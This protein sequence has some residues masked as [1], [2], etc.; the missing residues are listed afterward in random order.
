MT[1]LLGRYRALEAPRVVGLMSGTS[2][3]AIDAALVEVGERP[4]LLEFRSH[5]LPD[6]V[7]ARL[8]EVFDDRGTPRELTRLHW[9][10]GELFARAALSVMD[11]GADLVAS[12]GQT[13]AHLPEA[14]E[15]CGESVRGTL[16]LGEA[17]V[18]ARRTGCLVA[19]DF[20]PADMVAGGQGAPLVP[21]ADARLFHDPSR[22][23][24]ALNLGG[25]ANLTWIP[26]RGE[27]EACDTGPGNALMDALALRATG[28]AC[29]EGGRL[30]VRG[31]VLPEVLDELMAHPYLSRPAPKSTG[32]EEFGRPVAERLWGRG[33][34][35]DLLRTA[36]AFTAASVALHV[37]RYRSG[38]PVEL[39]AAGGGVENPVLME[40]LRARLPAG[41]TLRRMDE[42]GIPAQA[43][44][45]MAFALLGHETAH[46]RPSNVPRATGASGPVVLGKLVFP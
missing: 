20:R 24:I 44:E 30:A 7:R 22:D 46:G 29:D 6:E 1:D 41:V 14:E 38:R 13:V 25:M 42:L 28:Q 8:H 45:A 21:F 31:R 33:S 19:C 40:E 17:A 4:R 27:V 32:R 11:S 37:E 10:L 3:D 39:L 12:H 26:A 2:A 35:E 5:P 23:R 34:A 36:A 15:F 16:Q 43:R 9:L 18:L